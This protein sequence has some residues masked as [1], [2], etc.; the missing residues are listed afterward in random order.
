MS[1]ERQTIERAIRAIRREDRKAAALHAVVDA[2]AVFLVAN[3]LARALEFSLPAIG[4]LR[5]AT[6]V[7]AGVGLLVGTIEFWLRVRGDPVERFEAANPVVADALRTARDAATEAQ[8][9]PMARRC[10]R[11]VTERLQRTSAAG[12]LD[13]RWLSAGALVVVLAS[14]LTVQAAV[15]G[16]AFAPEGTAPDEGESDDSFVGPDNGRS[17]LQ[18]PEDVL[19]ERKQAAEGRDELDLNVSAGSG[20]GAGDEVREYE[21]SG[22]SAGD[23]AVAAREAGFAADRNLEDADLVREYNL[24]VQAGDSDD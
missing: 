13:T 4:P 16:V 1:E 2:V 14:A 22:L 12:F 24:R 15:A 5:G 19:G 8:D 9:T 20:G 23:D 18:D 10:Y 3:L 11:D 17:E 7:A 21:D 6:L